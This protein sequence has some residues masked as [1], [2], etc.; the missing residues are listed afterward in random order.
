MCLLSKLAVFSGHEQKQM[1]TVHTGTNMKHEAL[2]RQ[3]TVDSVY[4]I[5][6]FHC[7]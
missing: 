6:Q 7:E 2:D 4:N 1:N 3:G 5:Y